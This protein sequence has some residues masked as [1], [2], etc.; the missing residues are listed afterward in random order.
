M[1]YFE[2]AEGETI[3]RKRVVK[4]FKDHGTYEKDQADFFSKYPPEH[5]EFDAQAVLSFLGY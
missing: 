4:E 2:S 3:D 1:D 5:D